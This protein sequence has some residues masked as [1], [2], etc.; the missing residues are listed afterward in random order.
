[1]D[2]KAL[3]AL[4]QS[5]GFG[6]VRNHMSAVEPEVVERVKRH[7][8][9]QKSTRGRRGAHPADRRQAPRACVAA[10]A[11]P[12]DTATDVARAAASSRR[13]SRRPPCAPRRASQRRRAPRRRRRRVRSQ[14]AAPPPTRGRAGVAPSLRPEAGPRLQRRAAS[15][16]ARRTPLGPSLRG[17]SSRQR[18]APASSLRA[19]ARRLERPVESGSAP[20]RRA[21]AASAAAPREP[22][23]AAAPAAPSR[24]PPPAVPPPP[25]VRDAPRGR[26]RPCRPALQPAAC[27]RTPTPPRSEQSR[28]QRRRRP[29]RPPRR[30][31]PASRRGRAARACRCRQP[32]P[33]AAGAPV[34][35]HLRS[36]LER[37]HRRAP[38]RASALGAARPPGRPMGRPG[39]A[40][41]ARAAPARVPRD[42]AAMRLHAGDVR[43]Q[44]GHQ[45]R[46]EDHAPA[47]RRQ[48]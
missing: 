4:F 22:P 33:R 14:V 27:G 3:V 16:V 31:R 9:R 41:H 39:P 30:R 23:A 11:R 44:E 13:E 25:P 34:R 1:M 32:R 48:A 45:D 7:L 19:A 10:D 38:R 35:T 26:R 5:M 29:R 15:C 21:G 42:A 28:S 12:F 8:E 47:A 20:S 43:A 37:G 2:Q 24:R 6:D 40:R 17:S 46:G 36:A 18:A